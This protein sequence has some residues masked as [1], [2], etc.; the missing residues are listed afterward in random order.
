VLFST[1]EGSVPLGGSNDATGTGCALA[2]R[3]PEGVPDCGIEL[4]ERSR[5]N[6]AHLPVCDR[7][8]RLVTGGDAS[9]RCRS[10]LALPPANL[11]DASGVRLP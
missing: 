6:P 10:G 2:N 8:R 3:T 4:D 9:R 5:R 7:D 1:C 11:L